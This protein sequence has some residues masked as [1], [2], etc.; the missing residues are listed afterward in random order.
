MN[1]C[2]LWWTPK[3]YLNRLIHP[4]KAKKRL[5]ERVWKINII[6]TYFQKI[7]YI[8]LWLL[9]HNIKYNKSLTNLACTQKYLWWLEILLYIASILRSKHCSQGWLLFYI[10]CWPKH[11]CNICIP[12][13]LKENWNNCR[14]HRLSIFLHFL[15]PTWIDI[16]SFT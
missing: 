3:K 10:D 2:F 15:F 5:D 13:I 1:G 4:S 14:S 9:A 8:L 11:F 7:I 6:F 12:I 16:S